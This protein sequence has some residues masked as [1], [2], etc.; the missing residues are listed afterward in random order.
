MG[1]GSLPHVVICGGGFAGIA[2]A[3][4]LR[5]AP[6]QVTLIDRCNHHLFQPL[7]YQVATAGLSPG[8]IAEPIR[9]ILSGQANARVLLAR[10][11]SIQPDGRRVTIDGGQ[12][13][14]CDYLLLATGATHSYFGKDAWAAHAPGLKT[15]EDALELRRRILFAFEA[16]ERGGD[17]AEREALLTFVIVGAGPTG[18]ELAGA[19]IELSRHTLARE[20]RSL[21]P[22]RA[23]IVLCEGLDRVLSAF[24]PAL[25]AR[26]AE[27]LG[28][29]GVEVRTGTLVTEV[30]AAGVVLRRGEAEE[31]LPARTV[32][33]AAGV[34]AS[35]LG[36]SLG[37]PL[38]RAGRVL[39][40]PDLSVPG[41]RQVF[42]AGDLAAVEREDG[43]PVPGVAPAALQMGEHVARC[44]RADLAA[45]PRPP[46]RYRDKGDLA[47]IGRSSAVARIGRLEFGGVVAWLLWAVVHIFFLIGFR[48]RVLVSL[49]WVWAYLTYQRGARLI[50]GPVEGGLWSDLAARARPADGPGSAP[51]AASPPAG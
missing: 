50:T 9:R 40:E 30:D 48:N 4:G 2:A 3:R 32:L 35:P 18:V 44:I 24:P 10:V 13:L 21:D 11:E 17:A 33:W 5:R 20:F 41:R 51:D 49:Q 31:R 19:L 25:S 29:L 23:R 1:A 8:E 26:A 22:R 34:A 47:T 14:S 27:R 36:R 12:E 37:A 46:F 42:V 38:D 15:V 43:A 39:V 45:R 28:K 16:A 6:V 7:L